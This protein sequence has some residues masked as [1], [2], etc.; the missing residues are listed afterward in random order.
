[1]KSLFAFLLAIGFV[2]ACSAGDNGGLFGRW[3]NRRAA[4]A[5]CAACNTITATKETPAVIKTESV[6]KKVGE[7]VT[8]V[9]V[10]SAAKK[11]K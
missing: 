3:H 5:E 4:K 10:E 11:S 8:I 9:P 2:S 7:K 1:M 6:Y